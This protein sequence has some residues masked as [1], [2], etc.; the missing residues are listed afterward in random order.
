MKAVSR[1]GEAPAAHREHGLAMRRAGRAPAA[2][3][4]GPP[5]GGRRLALGLVAARAPECLSARVVICLRNSR[6]GSPPDRGE[7]RCPTRLDADRARA[8]PPQGGDARNDPHPVNRRQKM[9]QRVASSR[10]GTAASMPH[11]VPANLGEINEAP[12]R[13]APKPHA[14][15]R[16]RAGYKSQRVIVKMSAASRFRAAEFVWEARGKGGQGHYEGRGSASG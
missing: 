10:N 7:T 11:E 14:D 6:Q 9:T 3:R 16:R 5:W 12:R 13:S 2:R 8:R 1:A 4:Q 15:L